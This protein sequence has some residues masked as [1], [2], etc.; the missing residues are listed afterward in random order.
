MDERTA[1]DRY[2]RGEGDPGDLRQVRRTIH[3]VRDTF[4]AA[5]RRERRPG[6]ARL[7]LL[8]VDRIK[9]RPTAKLPSL[10]E[11]AAERGLEDFSEEEQIEAYEEAYR[12]ADNGQAS[13]SAAARRD[14]LID[15]QLEALR[16]LEQLVA[17]DPG[18]AD[19]VDAWFHP[20]IAGRLRRAGLNTLDALVTHMNH[21]GA[22][23]WR[24]VPAI[25]LH[26]GE[27]ISAWL[28]AHAPRLG[29]QLQEHALVQRSKLTKQGRA[30]AV[31]A[32]T[33]LRPLEKFLVPHELDGSAGCRRAGRDRLRLRA[34][35]DLEAVNAWIDAKSLGDGRSVL[36]ATQRSYRKEVER[37]LLW[38]V[39][40]QRKALSSLEAEDL[41]SYAAFLRQPP[42]TWC[43]PRSHP[44]W[45]PKWRP[46][47][48]P[49]SASAHRQALVILHGLFQYL[50]R[51]G[52]TE[53][54]PVAEMRAKQP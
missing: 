21:E 9:A 51:V 24:K 13:G 11:F 45:S 25:G 43:G 39:L 22:R 1:W 28:Q 30:A 15:R 37:L 10:A 18:P 16:W 52:W 38:A 8:D 41:Q 7:V 35:T 48:G 23:W 26:K 47:E 4:A 14:R 5:A 31:Q 44:R 46:L 50:N 19:G 53:G 12:G 40:V 49:L 42:S 54:N 27:R 17:R 36:T 6:T 3:W 32:A 20:L 29:L 2:L 34:D 33:A